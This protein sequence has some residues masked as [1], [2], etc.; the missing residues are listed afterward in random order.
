M[1]KMRTKEIIPEKTPQKRGTDSYS[2]E[3]ACNAA[4]NSGTP[5]Y[6]FA[7][8]DRVQVGQL[9]NCVVEEVMD[10]GAMYLIRIT[11]TNHVEYSCWAWTSVR[12]LDDDKT[13][14]SQSATLHYPVC[15]TQI[16]ACT[17]YS[18]IITCSVLISTPIISA[19]LF[20]MRRTERNCW[21][22][23][24]QDAKLVVSS[25]SSCPLIVQTTMATTTKSSMV[26]SVC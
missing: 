26:S 6:R 5:T 1:A 19:V 21:T 8:G 7:V 20:G 11:T 23:S 14:I 18:A 12:P 3:K 15:T 4:K 24:S 17:P 25:S 16:A 22:A 13:R 9:P 2:Y 10:D